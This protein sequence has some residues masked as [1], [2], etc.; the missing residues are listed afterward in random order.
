EEVL[1]SHQVIE[2]QIFG[3]RKAWIEHKIKILEQMPPIQVFLGLN[4]VQLSAEE[5]PGLPT[6]EEL[7]K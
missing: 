1:E 6:R 2:L 3:E 5:V 7:R 4:A